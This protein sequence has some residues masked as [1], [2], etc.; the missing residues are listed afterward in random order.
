MYM[1]QERWIGKSGS[2]LT[3]CLQ[4]TQLQYSSVGPNWDGIL[5]SA[6]HEDERVSLNLACN[7]IQSNALAPQHNS[8][9]NWA[10]SCG[11]LVRV[12]QPQQQIPS[13][14]CCSKPSTFWLQSANIYHLSEWYSVYKKHHKNIEERLYIT[15]ICH[16]KDY[17]QVRNV[18][19]G[20]NLVIIKH[21]I[22]C[23]S[24]QDS[25]SKNKS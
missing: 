9:V 22:S 10:D 17:H 3:Q 5:R 1:A 16:C 12:S 19:E 18:E 4:Q 20:Y 13:L 21:I 11:V 24:I 7:H 14:L 25:T 6:A 15:N 23:D 2:V 8:H